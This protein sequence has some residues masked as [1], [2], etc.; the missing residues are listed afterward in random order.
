[1][2]LPLHGAVAAR[3]QLPPSSE[4]HTSEHTSDSNEPAPSPARSARSPA[5]WF[6][7]P[8]GK[9]L[10]RKETSCAP[11]RGDHATV[12]RHNSS[13]MRC[14]SQGLVTVPSGRR[15]VGLH[16]DDGEGAGARWMGDNRPQVT[17]LRSA[18]RFLSVTGTA[19]GSCPAPGKGVV[20]RCP[21]RPVPMSR[22]YR[23]VET[24]KGLLYDLVKQSRCLSALGIYFIPRQ[25]SI[26]PIVGI[27]K[28]NQ[29][30]HRKSRTPRLTSRGSTL[31]RPR[32]PCRT[33]CD[34]E[35]RLPPA[36]QTLTQALSSI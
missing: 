31:Q 26:L 4:H 11:S 30:S 22:P 24:I 21:K 25:A 5:Y 17:D 16:L 1:M 15:L 34:L 6:Q 35:I 14:S 12:S 23:W 20:G 3:N 33:T 8:K 28:P 32:P 36:P 29:K 2:C 10:S 13:S 9:S 18:H 19:P 27:S 7:P